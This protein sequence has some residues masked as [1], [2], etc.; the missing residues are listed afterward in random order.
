VL[1]KTMA[2]KMLPTRD[3]W[4]GITHKDDLPF[5]ESQLNQLIAQGLYSLRIPADS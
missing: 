2:M 4:L 3:R 1:N 5:V